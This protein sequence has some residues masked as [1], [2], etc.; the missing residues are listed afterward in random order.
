MTWHA[1]R[2]HGSPPVH[3]FESSTSTQTLA[4][5]LAEYYARNPGLQRGESL[6]PEARAFFR[7]HD[8]VH[9][10]YGCST[11][12][13]DEAVVKLASI[14]GTTGGLSVLRGYM[15]HDSIDIYRKLPFWSTVTALLM[16]PC[17]VVRT[18]WRCARQRAKWPWPDHEKYMDFPLQELRA[19]YGIEVAHAALHRAD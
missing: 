10:L 11:S 9:V 18:S 6:T 17:L 15:L 14:F 2:N 1:P 16:A 5:A 8:V 12:M 13:P 4:E 7:S 3:Q 19:E